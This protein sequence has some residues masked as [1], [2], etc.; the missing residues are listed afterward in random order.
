[1]IQDNLF[2]GLCFCDTRISLTVK[3]A[4]PLSNWIAELQFSNAFNTPGAIVSS[5]WLF[6]T[7]D[8]E[9]G[10]VSFLWLAKKDM[11]KQ[12]LDL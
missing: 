10:E 5:S 6:Q 8:L 2:P 3:I 7:S 1:L 11:T 9:L 4:H 12:G